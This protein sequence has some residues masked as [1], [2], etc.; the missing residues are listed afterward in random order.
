VDESIFPSYLIGGVETQSGPGN[1]TPF[2]NVAVGGTVNLLTP[3]FTTRPTAEITYG[4]DNYQSQFSNF[5]TT[6]SAGKLQ[7]VAST[8][9]GGINGP[10]Y[11]TDKCVVDLGQRRGKR[12]PAR[13]HWDHPVLRRRQRFVLQ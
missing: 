5:L 2:A 1:T 8:G 11:E 6:G 13:Q 10:Y 7:Y 9:V 4:V 3:G 12:E